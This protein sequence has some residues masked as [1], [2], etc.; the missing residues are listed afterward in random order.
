M[1]FSKIILITILAMALAGISSLSAKTIG[2]IALKIGKVEYREGKG[3]WKKAR[4]GM[5]V[6]TKMSI[7]TGFKSKAIIKMNTGTRLTLKPS[8]MIK[9]SNFVR[10]KFGTATDLN[11]RT[12]RIRSVVAKLKKGKRNHF[13]VRTP[14]AVAGVRGTIGDFGES[15][16]GFQ[17]DL[18]QD[19]AE[20]FQGG[21]RSQIQQGDTGAAQGGPEQRL[22]RPDD[23]RGQELGIIFFDPT[24]SP[25]QVDAMFESFE[26]TFGP[27]GDFDFLQ[28]LLI[29]QFGSFGPEI[30]EFELL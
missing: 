29:D 1:K 12:G 25:E 27:P 19:S 24:L 3:K 28:D 26:P 6:T 4:I 7:N 2:R 5:K 23:V 22:Q 10:G 30:V 8:T 14:T 16:M 15:N 21:Q 13:R 9:F 20:M 18:S 17:A 11:M